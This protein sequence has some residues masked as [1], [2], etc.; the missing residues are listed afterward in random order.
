MESLIVERKREAGA[1]FSYEICWEHGF[2]SLPSRIS[3]MKNAVKKIC[4]VSDSNVAALYL[5]PVC[6]LLSDSGYQVF[7]YIFPAGEENKN[8]DTVQKLYHFLIQKK[9]E[10]KDILAALGGG[11]TGDLTGYAAATYLRGVDFIQIPTTLLAQ[12]D[13]S[14]G[15]KTGVDF[16]CYKNMVGAF[17][18]P[19][20]VYMNMD[21]LQTLPEQQFI[22]GMGEVLKT[23]LIRDKSFYEWIISHQPQIAAKDPDTMAYVIREC[24][25]IKAEVVAEDPHEQ[26][27]RVILNLGH[28]IGHAVEKLMNFQMLHGQCVGLGTAGAAWLS[29]QRGWISEKDYEKILK[30]NRMFHLPSSLQGL[31]PNTVLETTRS[32]KKMEEG[33]IKFRLLKGLGNAVVDRSVTDAELLGAIQTLSK[34]E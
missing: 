4:L 31:D 9:F 33:K 14:V 17:H 2:N 1:E 26:G 30:A 29:L 10:R 25:R 22:S 32:D 11:V 8:L 21:T 24:C 34:T 16:D 3:A 6:K 5:D 28:T 20:L 15:G 12:V 19:S 7:P 18:Q 27:L 13:S 23:G